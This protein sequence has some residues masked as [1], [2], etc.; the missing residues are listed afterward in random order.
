MT[1]V[2]DYPAPEALA[3]ACVGRGLRRDDVSGKAIGLP[4]LTVIP[5]DG[6]IHA[7]LR[8]GND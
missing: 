6:R 5:P 7:S 8:A 3:E 4:K 1:E 2:V